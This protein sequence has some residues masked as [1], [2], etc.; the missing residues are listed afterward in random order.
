MCVMRL[1]ITL[2]SIFWNWRIIHFS[3]CRHTQPLLVQMPEYRLALVYLALLVFSKFSSLIVTAYSFHML[4]NL[5][6]TLALVG[7]GFACAAFIAGQSDRSN[8]NH[9]H[10]HKSNSSKNQFKSKNK[11]RS[12]YVSPV[13]TGVEHWCAMTMQGD[14]TLIEVSPEDTVGVIIF[15]R[16]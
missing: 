6:P 13:F 15:T 10:N 14:G 3:L 8:R 11:S 5:S 2:F 9:N 7:F 12:R 4:L 16:L 1:L